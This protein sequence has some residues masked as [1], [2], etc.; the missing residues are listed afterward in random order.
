MLVSEAVS[1]TVTASLAD[2]EAS[3]IDCRGCVPA[4]EPTMLRGGG[5]VMRTAHRDNETTIE[6]RSGGITGKERRG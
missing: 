3:S 4:A 6:G 5:L 1:F 2:S